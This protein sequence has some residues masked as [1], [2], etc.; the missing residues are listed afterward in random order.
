MNLFGHT[1]VNPSDLIAIGDG[2]IYTFKP[3]TSI[4]FLLAQPLSISAGPAQALWPEFGLT[5]SRK[6]P[7][8]EFWRKLTRQR[9]NGRFNVLFSDGHTENLKV[10]NLFDHRRDDVL[11]RWFADNRPNRAGLPLVP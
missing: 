4:E 6:N 7:D 9:H 3:P 5:P 1:V 2:L 11:R 8:F 10:Q